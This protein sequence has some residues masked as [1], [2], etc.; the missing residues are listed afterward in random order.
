[1]STRKHCS[2]S[3]GSGADPTL[4]P[5]EISLLL[6]IGRAYPSPRAPLRPLSLYTMLVLAYCAGLRLSEIAR[7]DLGDVD[8]QSG[9]I[10]IR[11]T[12]FFKSRILPLT[13]SALA[14][15]RRIENV[16]AVASKA[17]SSCS[18]S[19]NPVDVHPHQCS[20]LSVS[21]TQSILRPATKPTSIQ[22][23]PV[24]TSSTCS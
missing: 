13:D 2:R 23:E 4:S 15:N 1:M 21:I 10:T 18:I 16:L 9:T 6:N 8:L 24:V 11:E 22:I 20:E 5:E 7:L 14:A 19:L 12:K 17:T 3:R